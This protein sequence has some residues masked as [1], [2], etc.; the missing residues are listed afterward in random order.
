MNE[1]STILPVLGALAS[2]V[3]LGM[4]LRARLIS[5]NPNQARRSTRVVGDVT[6]TSDGIVASSGVIVSNHYY[7][8]DDL[9]PKEI[10]AELGQI[11]REVSG[12]GFEDESL[13]AV[14]S[15]FGS[16]VAGTNDASWI[17]ESPGIFVRGPAGPL[18]RVDILTPD[19][20]ER[21]RGFLRSPSTSQKARLI[22]NDWLSGVKRQVLSRLAEARPES[23][24]VAEL[25]D[26]PEVP[27]AIGE[28]SAGL[29][30]L[31][32]ILGPPPLGKLGGVQT[33]SMQ[34]GGERK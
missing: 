11:L 5:R 12:D 19:T 33:P 32:R 22:A 14:R 30:D 20:E 10:A 23:L 34:P 16:E 25:S 27:G 2:V 9:S 26:D 31:F 7:A 4:I 6:V 28:L 17:H 21:W 24:Q 18:I 3:P 1:L 8:A 29:N 15:Y 13:A